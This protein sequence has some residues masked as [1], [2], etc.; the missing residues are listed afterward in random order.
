MSISS[1]VTWPQLGNARAVGVLSGVGA[2]PLITTRRAG[3]VLIAALLATPAAELGDQMPQKAP[4]AA[5]GVR[6]QPPSMQIRPWHHGNDHH[7]RVD[8]Q[9]SGGRLRLVLALGSARPR[10]PRAGRLGP[11]S[12]GAC[13]SLDPCS[14][15][16]AALIGRCED[17]S[18]TCGPRGP[19]LR[20]LGPLL[21]RVRPESGLIPAGTGAISLRSAPR[22]PVARP[23]LGQSAD[24]Q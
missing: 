13:S 23:A 16:E 21:P 12:N 7:H 20:L 22:A 8:S 11:V 5:R 15:S 17:P 2:R 14:D 24:G 4:P 6:P 9:P 1:I 3:S 18:L 19:C 10:P